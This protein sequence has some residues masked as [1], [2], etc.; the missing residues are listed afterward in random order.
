MKRNEPKMSEVKKQSA[1]VQSHRPDFRFL[2]NEGA[3]S[4]K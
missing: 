2:C 1:D 3:R 4:V